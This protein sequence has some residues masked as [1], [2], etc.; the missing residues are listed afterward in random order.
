VEDVMNKPRYKDII[1]SIQVLEDMG[2]VVSTAEYLHI[3]EAVKSDIEQRMRNA[4]AS[5]PGPKLSDATREEVIEQLHTIRM[6]GCFGDGMESEYIY[7]GCNMVGLN[8]MSDTELVDELTQCLDEDDEDVI[9]ARSELDV[10]IMLTN[11]DQ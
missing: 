3:L 2:G 7:G 9:K 10:E 1:A 4:K 6:Q 5:N 11:E 8:D